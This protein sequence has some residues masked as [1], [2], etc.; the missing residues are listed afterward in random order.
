MAPEMAYE[1]QYDYKIDVWAL[2]V[3]IYELVHG[4]APFKAKNLD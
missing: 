1:K 3:L 2:G 4:H